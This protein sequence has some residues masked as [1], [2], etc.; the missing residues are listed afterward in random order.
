MSGKLLNIIESAYRATLEEQDDTIVW[1]THALRGAGAPVDVL[2]EGNAVNY[3][4]KGQTVP[5]LRFGDRQQDH[6]PKVHE[7]LVSLVA[8]GVEVYAVEEDLQERGIEPGEIATEVKV[9]GFA[10][11][12]KLIG[13]YDQI[14]RW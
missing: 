2:L 11:V 8:K 12:P 3:A 9:V 10:D 5:A 14:W 4:V 7:D 1:L 6:A 13:L